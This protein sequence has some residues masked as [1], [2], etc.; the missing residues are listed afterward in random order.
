MNRRLGVWV[1]CLGMLL[2]VSSIGLFAYNLW[3]ENRAALA[4]AST[5]TALC[6]Q[7][8]AQDALSDVKEIEIDG[9]QYIGIL[10]IPALGLELPINKEW[11]Y[12]KLKES[13][14]R[15]AGDVSG[16]LTIAAHNYK[17]HFGNVS[18]LAYDDTVLLTEVDGHENLYSVKEVVIIQA[19]GI[20]EMVNS[21]YDLTLFTCTYG[22]K[23]RVA[24]R[25]MR[26]VPSKI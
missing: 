7:M 19:T 18:S 20:D 3:D 16:S 15:Y 5:V 1:I 25:C 2:V 26:A 14:C 8:D 12:P 11:S 24:I 22:G 9:E 17:N 4:A 23:G 6:E 21:S 13:P 10:R